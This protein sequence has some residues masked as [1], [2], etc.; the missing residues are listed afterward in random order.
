M[1]AIIDQIWPK[2]LFHYVEHIKITLLKQLI[3]KK[4]FPDNLNE[5]NQ[6]EDKTN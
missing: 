6:Y 4:W 3:T 1:I 2:S 5:D